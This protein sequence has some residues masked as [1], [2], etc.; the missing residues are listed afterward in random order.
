MIVFSETQIRSTE[1]LLS[2]FI[3]LLLVQ[4]LISAY[5]KPPKKRDKLD[6]DSPPDTVPVTVEESSSDEEFIPTTDDKADGTWFIDDDDDDD[7]DVMMM[8]MITRTSLCLN[9]YN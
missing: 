2:I 1:F 3:C 4:D 6:L 8:K 5:D 7:D 9:V